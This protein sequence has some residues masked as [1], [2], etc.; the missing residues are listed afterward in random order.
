MG[1]EKENGDPGEEG[2]EDQKG[3]EK[4]EWNAVTFSQARLSVESLLLEVEVLF[5]FYLSCLSF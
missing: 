5:F 4:G 1:E 2:E 3:E